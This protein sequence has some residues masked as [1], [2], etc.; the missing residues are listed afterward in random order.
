MM[1]SAKGLQ[2]SYQPSQVFTYPDIQCDTGESLLVQGASG[3]GKSTLLH[4]L[5]GL[6]KPTM[7]NVIIKGIDLH[8]LNDRKLDTF[9]GKEI[10][11]ITQRFHFIESI[12]VEDNIRAAGYFSGKPID[13]QFL[14]SIIDSLKINGL[15]KIKPLDLSIGEQQRVSIAR[16]VVNRPSLLLADEPTSSLDD[17]NCHEVAQILTSLAKDSGASL[18]IVT[19]DE[20]LKRKYPHQISLT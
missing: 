12:S 4:L 20:R 9:R 18:I 5:A 16:A 1:V 8:H 6:L 17:R 10:G 3:C 13:E 2:F 15:M 14:K 7:G 19:H 11:I